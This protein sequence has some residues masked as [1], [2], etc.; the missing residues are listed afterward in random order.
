LQLKGKVGGVDHNP[1]EGFTAGIPPNALTIQDF[2]SNLMSDRENLDVNSFQYNTWKGNNGL[3]YQIPEVAIDNI[4]GEEST[5]IEDRIISLYN[6]FANADEVQ[7]IMQR[8]GPDALQDYLNLDHFGQLQEYRQDASYIPQVIN[9]S[10]ETISLDG[11]TI[12]FADGT[13][14]NT[15]L[16]GDFAG[17]VGTTYNDF[18]LSFLTDQVANYQAGNDWDLTSIG[19][20]YDDD[21]YD[22]DG[23]DI[24]GYDRDGFNVD[25]INADGYN[26]EGYDSEGYDIAGY[27]RQMRDV[28]GYD[29]EGYDVEG[30]DVEGYDSEG[31]DVEGFNVEGYDVEGFDRQDVGFDGFNRDGVD[32]EGYDRDGYHAITGFDR[33]GFNSDGVNF[34]GLTAQEIIDGYTVS[35]DG[36]LV[37]PPTVVTGTP[38]NT[39]NGN[40][41]GLGLD[42]LGLDGLGL[43]GPD[44]TLDPIGEN[45]EDGLGIVAEPDPNTLNILDVEKLNE[46]RNRFGGTRRAYNEFLQSDEGKEKAKNLGD[47]I[48]DNLSPSGEFDMTKRA[49]L[50]DKI[51]LVATDGGFSGLNAFALGVNLVEGIVGTDLIDVPNIGYLIDNLTEKF[52]DDNLLSDIEKVVPDFFEKLTGIDQILQAN[53]DPS[54]YL[55][56]GFDFSA[57]LLGDMGMAREVDYGLR[58]ATEQLRQQQEDYFREFLGDDVYESFIATT[59]IEDPNFFE[60]IIDFGQNTLG[61]VGDFA[62]DAGFLQQKYLGGSLPTNLLNLLGAASLGVPIGSLIN[63]VGGGLAPSGQELSDYLYANGIDPT[64]QCS[65]I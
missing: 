10:N 62:Q 64:T 6:S 30:Y 58:P 20:G 11:S 36:T 39:D 1:L 7:F 29:V 44:L 60:K 17:D 8:F 21:G 40:D 41:D 32:V 48:N 47:F 4:T 55:A 65:R 35:E 16:S 5:D 45:D 15:N 49:E 24:E 26:T 2:V 46:I 61:G 56:Q 28:E 52:L 22:A 57:W 42:G 63:T 50:F 23:F 9:Q 34:D 38:D 3:T 54:G 53:S 31:F 14:F 12:T 18:Y 33:E 19:Y 13:A 27:D 43:D 59:P 37:L 51:A 25:G